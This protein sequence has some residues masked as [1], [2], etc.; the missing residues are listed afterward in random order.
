MPSKIE[1]FDNLVESYSRTPEQGLK[2]CKKKLQRDP[3]NIIHLLAQAS[4]LRDIG[5]PQ[6]ALASCD[7]I[8]PSP[9]DPLEPGLIISLQ[10]I[11]R[12]CQ[13]ELGNFTGVGG[14]RLSS[15]WKDALDQC[16]K[17]WLKDLRGEMLSSALR[18]GYWDIAQQLF[19]RL[20]RE[21]P[22]NSKYHFAWIALCQIQADKLPKDDKMGQSLKLLASRSLRAI[23][24]NTAARKDTIKKLT[25]PA[26]LRLLCQVYSCQGL[27]E[28]LLD[29]LN[30]PEMGITS[31][32]GKH[33]VEFVLIK[34]DVLCKL[35]RWRELEDFCMEGLEKLC[36]HY[37]AAGKITQDVPNH[38]AWAVSWQPWKTAL[39]AIV[40]D[41]SSGSPEDIFNLAQKYLTMDPHHRNAGNA[42]AFCDYLSKV[43]SSKPEGGEDERVLLRRVTSMI[44]SLKLRYLLYISQL[45][46][47]RETEVIGFIADCLNVYQ[48]MA[49]KQDGPSDDACILAIAGLMKLGYTISNTYNLQAGCLA[50]LLR[51]NSQYNFN[52]TLL[53]LLN[54]RT[55]G[56]GSI[57]IAAFRD[58]SLRE[59]Q[60]DTLGH[61]LY[62]RISTLHPFPVSSS[63]VKAWEDRYKD[64]KA[65]IRFSLLWPR[66]A[67]DA[68]LTTLTKDLDSV[69][70]DKFNEFIAFNARITNS[71]S[72]T[73]SGLELKRIKR[74]TDDLPLSTEIP[75]SYSF[76][77]SDNRDFAPIVDFESSKSSLSS[78]TIATGGF[79]P[80]T[81]WAVRMQVNE[82]ISVLLGLKSSAISDKQS[83]IIDQ[84]LKYLDE[85]ASSQES[86]LTEDEREISQKWNKLLSVAFWLVL[87]PQNSHASR[88]IAKDLAALTECLQAASLAMQTQGMNVSHDD[89]LEFTHFNEFECWYLHLEFAKACTLFAVSAAALVKQKGHHAQSAISMKVVDGIRSSARALGEAVQKQARSLQ[90]VLKT[91]GGQKVLDIIKGGG[92]GSVIERLTGGEQ[93]RRYVDDMVA[94][95]VEGLDGVLKV[96]FG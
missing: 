60:Y 16:P 8:K 17:Q 66:S 49:E 74:L 28:D 75:K 58:L 57:A 72:T 37:E 94:S 52:A 91:D 30:H 71:Y 36:S 78:K 87:G 65:S 95:A 53:Q 18:N 43:G 33:D 21:L 35:K 2:Y 42:M 5:R 41:G 89:G 84:L 92:L 54:A 55:L 39:N 68:T 76:A 93:L 38:L 50:Q 82:I 81:Y 6:D 3:S 73:M 23:V 10:N 62:T 77:F 13:E 24:D 79:K 63:D 19:A 32:V 7:A 11:V 83:E 9:K 80:G 44:N 59:V 31:H 64:P 85:H 34:M 51:D 12:D 86:E 27:F 1:V 45:G 56:L 26:D 47:G 4:F 69:F 25:A 40:E 22:Q 14:A 61:L 70:F 88:N 48:T 90:K 20:Q 15:L 29:V 46:E 96:K 67:T